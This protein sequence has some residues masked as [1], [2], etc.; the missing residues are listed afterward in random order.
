M[1]RDTSKGKPPD[2]SAAGGAY[3]PYPVPGGTSYN[4]GAT[5]DAS[6]QFDDN[7]SFGGVE[8]YALDSTVFTEDDLENLTEDGSPFE[9]TLWSL[10]L[11][12]AGVLAGTP[13]CRG[14][15]RAQSRGPRRGL[16]AEFIPG[17]APRLLDRIER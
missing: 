6:R 12:G 10:S 5:I 2:G 7:S 11:S 9:D 8:F 3:D 16:A 14:R 15:F 13:G 1:E 4:Y 17:Y